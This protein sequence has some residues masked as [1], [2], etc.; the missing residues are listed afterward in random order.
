MKKEKTLGEKVRQ[1]VRSNITGL[2]VA[3]GT[4]TSRRDI[5]SL[6][7]L[8]D[9]IT[10][11]LDGDRDDSYAS[12]YTG[13][14]ETA[15]SASVT[16]LGQL[17]QSLQP[18]SEQVDSVR[19]TSYY[20]DAVKILEGAL[21]EE[22]LGDTERDPTYTTYFVKS[23]DPR[24]VLERETQRIRIEAE[25]MSDRHLRGHPTP[26]EQDALHKLWSQHDTYVLALA[27][28]IRAECEIFQDPEYRVFI[29]DETGIPFPSSQK[30]Q[31]YLGDPENP[32]G[33]YKIKSLD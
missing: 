6:M 3:V 8:P 32:D 21:V 12:R 14:E 29:I 18:T 16:Q 31:I 26:S 28:A 33:P 11:D 24:T 9:Q 13:N 5:F 7:R 22:S 17:E 30:S 2:I 19:S 4:M 23:E 10:L 15:A 20:A 1:R 25:E 27:D